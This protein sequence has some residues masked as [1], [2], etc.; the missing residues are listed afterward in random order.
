MVTFK[1]VFAEMM[2]YTRFI[3]IN[4]AGLLTCAYLAEQLQKIHLLHRKKWKKG[5]KYFYKGA[6]FFIKRPN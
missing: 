4:N 6:H 2:E 5:K 3:A 1:F